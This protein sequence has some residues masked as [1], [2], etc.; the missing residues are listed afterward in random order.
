MGHVVNADREH[1]L[2]RRQLDRTI[3]GAPDSPVLMKILQLLFSAQ[4]AELA[5]RLP[6]QLT[7]LKQ[8]AVHL[9]VPQDEL[10]EQLSEMARRGVVLDIEHRGQRYF[11]LAPIA[12]GFFEFVFMRA[13]DDLPMAELS[14]L[15]EQYMHADDRLSRSVFEGRTQPARALV[16]EETLPEGDHTEVLDWERASHLVRTA[17]AIGVSLCA[18]RHQASHLGT[19]CGQPQRCCLSLNFAAESLIR[20]AMAQRLTEAQALQVLEDCQA[21]GLVQLGDNVQRK[22]VYLCN[23]CGCCCKMIQ[24]VKRFELR[25]AIATSNWILQV[26]VDRCKGCGKCAQACPVDAIEI[27]AEP[28]GPKPRKRAACDES[29]CLGCGV[30]VSRCKFGALAMTSRPRRILTPE[31]C[32]DRVV[33]MAIDRGKLAELVFDDPRRLSHRALGRIVGVI[34]KSPVFKAAMA[35]EPLRSAFLNRVV[36]V[37]KKRTREFRELFQ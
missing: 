21:A 37:A 23:C 35:I 27:V 24:A 13:R 19:A 15:F 32:V 17:S 26:D 20:N 2:L 29:L 1:R 16:R 12:F 14:R 33:A 6:G 28:D 22:P 30:C 25:G 9:D 34:E 36:S 4:E 11:A 8:L 7:P 5:G 31:T 10:D 3:T 18:C